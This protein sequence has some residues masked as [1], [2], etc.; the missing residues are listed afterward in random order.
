MTT[1][2]QPAPL[3]INAIIDSDS[4]ETYDD[5]EDKH[6][7][8][9]EKEEKLIKKAIANSLD[10]DTLVKVKEK[11]TQET[12]VLSLEEEEA[13]VFIMLKCSDGREVQINK[14]YLK[15][16]NLWE[17]AIRG[18]QSATSLDIP[19]EITYE[20]IFRI[21][22]YINHHKGVSQVDKAI[23]Q[24]LKSVDLSTLHESKFD[25]KYIDDDWATDPDITYKLI[26]A[27]NFLHI[28]CLLYL[29][30]A[31]VAAMIKGKP[32]DKLPEIL[33]TKQDLKEN[34][35]FT[36]VDVDKDDDKDDDN[37]DTKEQPESI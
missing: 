15:I 25:I 24:P 12:Q 19:E 23:E 3:D 13:P 7:T 27:A 17:E 18:D 6:D 21:V 11:V 26:L 36:D 28:Q 29:C 33:S 37:K 1:S 20:T 5:Q 8:Q 9:D 32:L 2:V 22:E 35:K 4:D 34:K 10:D 14:K 16:C 31:K 30:S